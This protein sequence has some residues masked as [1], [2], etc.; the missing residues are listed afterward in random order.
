MKRRDFSRGLLVSGLTAPFVGT[1]FRAGA[2]QGGAQ[3]NLARVFLEIANRRIQPDAL[4]FLNGE[5]VTYKINLRRMFPLFNEDR[6]HV[7]GLNEPTLSVEF[8][9]AHTVGYVRVIN[10]TIAV[11]PKISLQKSY[12][13]IHLAN[14]GRSYIIGKVLKHTKKEASI[15]SL[16]GIPIVGSLFRNK[17]RSNEKESLLILVRPSIVSPDG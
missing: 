9:G 14:G 10:N 15:P 7:P 3:V 11:T 5:Q 2:D 13:N 4:V 12:Q 17:S 1:G 16:A 6:A 8:K